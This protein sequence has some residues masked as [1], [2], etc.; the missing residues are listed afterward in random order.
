MRREKP[1]MQHPCNF[2]LKKDSQMNKCM[3]TAL[4]ALALFFAGGV[5]APRTS[6][7][8]L[9]QD[10]VFEKGSDAPGA[11]PK[12]AKAQDREKRRG[13]RFA[14]CDKDKDG[15]LSKDEFAACYPRKAAKF[16]EIDA[17][18]DGNVTKEEMKAYRT[19][20]Q[21][22]RMAKFDA[23]FAE[24]DKD[25]DGTLSKEEFA[26]CFPKRADKFDAIDAN[27]DGKVTKEEMKTARK[28]KSEK[29]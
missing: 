29:Q 21:K 15:M 24:C 6:M 27:K 25:K 14:E 18:K 17:N 19:V 22:E 2:N 11:G 7:Q 16:D 20:M 4:A 26:A 23:K 13:A 9:A 8:A 10:V 3:I 1:P 12:G 5:L 28:P